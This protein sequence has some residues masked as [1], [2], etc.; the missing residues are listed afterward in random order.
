MRVAVQPVVTAEFASPGAP[1]VRAIEA[2]I[3]GL[4]E[5][6]GGHGVALVGEG[7]DGDGGGQRQRQSGK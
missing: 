3:D 2:G 1:F 5:P 6:S 4:S 7:G